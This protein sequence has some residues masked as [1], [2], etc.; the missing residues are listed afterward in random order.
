M[1]PPTPSKATSG[2]YP[3]GHTPPELVMMIDDDDDDEVHEDGNA[4]P[5]SRPVKKLAA[6]WQNIVD[7]S[8]EPDLVAAD[9]PKPQKNKEFR[10]M[11]EFWSKNS[12]GF[13]GAP[14]GEHKNSLSK[15]EAQA[16]LQRLLANGGMASHLD[17]VRKLR[18][19]IAQE[20]ALSED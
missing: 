12:K 15:T 2:G 3:S 7:K 14:L 6:D 5:S 8:A 1:T 19:Q 11:R 4:T 18:K 17:E 16:Q 9:R 20:S 10:D 13:V